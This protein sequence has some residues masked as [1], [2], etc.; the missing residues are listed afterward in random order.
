M[1]E[2]TDTCLIL[3]SV[4]EIMKPGFDTTTQLVCKYGAIAKLEFLGPSQ[5]GCKEEVPL[6]DPIFEPDC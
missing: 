5:A 3:P 1:G 6:K 4:N 2:E